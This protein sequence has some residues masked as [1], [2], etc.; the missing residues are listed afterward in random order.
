MTLLMHL[1]N[2]R[3]ARLGVLLLVVLCLPAVARD[4]PAV[5]DGEHLWIVEPG[6]EVKGNPTLRIVHHAGSASFGESTELDP[7]NGA[8]LQRGL[9]AGDGRL[10]LVM[11]NRQLLTLRPVWS[12]LTRTWSY[13]ERRLPILPEGCTLVSLALGSRGPWAL[14]RVESA[15]L[16]E[17]LDN[18][19]APAAR[20]DDRASL[21]RVLGLPEDFGIKPPEPEEPTEETPEEGGE[22]EEAQGTDEPAES[23]TESQATDQPT[24]E[25]EPAEPEL[26]AYRL[27]HLPRG[28]WA[29]S[30][31]PRDFVEPKHIE[32][33]LRP[34][35]DR[36]TLIVEH[37]LP[38]SS[39]TALVRY[40]PMDLPEPESGQASHDAWSLIQTRSRPMP[41]R[42]WS[43]VLVQGQMFMVAERWRFNDSLHLQAYL[44]RGSDARPMGGQTLPATTGSRWAALPWD[45]A[46]GLIVRPL[47]TEPPEDGKASE[48]T[49]LAVLAA[50]GLDGQPKESP[51]RSDGLTVLYLQQTS[52]V[53]RNADLIIQIVAFAIAM[54]MMMLYYRQAPQAEDLDLPDKLVLASLGRR[55]IAGMIDLA[56]GFWLAGLLYG[57]SFQE[58]ALF[59]PGNG[60]AKALPAMRPGFIVI[61]VTLVHTTLFEFITARSMGKWVTGLYVADFNGKPADAG[62]CA[63]RAMSRVFELFAPLMIVLAIISPARQ[64]LGDILAKTIVVMPKP[65]PIDLDQNDDDQ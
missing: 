22:A 5:A 11:D 4:L 20:T 21:N 41:G 33:L 26:P 25:S 59:W 24:E 53:K 61:I 7:I 3:L 29:S 51:T 55:M 1:N 8:L 2:P 50:I 48:T 47:Q 35:A 18:A 34:G 54:L 32:M 52:P 49:T 42:L 40:S 64:R 45:G 39:Q 13:Q 15:Q 46:A 36:P 63:L 6:D 17:E 14:V 23:E 12:D 9:A 62:P 38:G 10:L 16:L 37:D 27:I 60:I 57:T 44:L 58:T 30:P 28:R 56:P 31:L 65:Q 43:A 19:S